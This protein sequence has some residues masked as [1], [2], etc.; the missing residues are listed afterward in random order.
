MAISPQQIVGFTS[1]LVLGWDFWNRRI[2][3]R[4][5]HF[6][7]IQDGGWAATLENSNGDIS[8]KDYSIHSMFGSRK[9]FSGTADL[10]TLFSV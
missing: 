9:G 5:F 6:Y 7:K 4:Y 10:M 2:E 8:A 3:W 1:C